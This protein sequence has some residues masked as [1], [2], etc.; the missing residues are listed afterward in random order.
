[1]YKT[2]FIIIVFFFGSFCC[3]AQ[4]IIE[5]EF[6]AEGLLSLTIEDDLIFNIKI[7]SS[8]RESIKINV[9][10]SGEHAEA[11]II[12]EKRSKGKLSLRTAV[13][14]YF[15][16]EDD[17]LAAHKLMAIEV[18][19]FIPEN[20]AVE[21]KSKLTSLETTGKIRNLSASLQKGSCTIIDFSGDA[22]IRTVDGNI[23]AKAQK[24]VCG[25]ALSK[26]G[27]V[28]NSLSKR[29]SFLLE[30]ESIN[31]DIYLLQTE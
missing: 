22:H 8:K 25:K 7:V 14:P 19:L 28:E 31:G 29:G 20:I 26:N 16:F 9:H 13:M 6:S 4:K 15:I 3:V 27:T 23:N 1:M 12:E 21:I 10:V 24:E 11:I 5:K 17:K 2:F 18:M 30:A